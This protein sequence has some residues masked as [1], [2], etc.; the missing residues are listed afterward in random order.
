VPSI[1]AID[2]KEKCRGAGAYVEFMNGAE[3][4]TR[5]SKRLA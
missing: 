2:N 3:K 5:A 1:P 4:A